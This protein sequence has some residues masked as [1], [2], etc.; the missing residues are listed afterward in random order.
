MSNLFD[1]PDG[2]REQADCTVCALAAAAA[3]EYRVAHAELKAA[4]RRDRKRFHMLRFMQGRESVLGRSV[5]RLSIPRNQLASFVAD[6]PVGR[7][8]VRK[9]GHCLA[10]VDGPNH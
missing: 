10:V 3:V 9:S 5:F 1:R 7:F 6:H 2:L 8:L 4:G